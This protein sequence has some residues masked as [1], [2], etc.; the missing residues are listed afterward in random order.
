M[1]REEQLDAL[2]RETLA[3]LDCGPT[4]DLDYESG[5]VSWQ[6]LVYRM[7]DELRAGFIRTQAP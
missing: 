2:V 5:R 6:R 4:Y 3:K 1:T 7:A